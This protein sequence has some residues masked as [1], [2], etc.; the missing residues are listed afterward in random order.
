[1]APG[2]GLAQRGDRW[3]SMYFF[4]CM[5]LDKNEQ[6]SLKIYFAWILALKIHFFQ[7]FIFRCSLTLRSCQPLDFW[8]QD[9]TA[10]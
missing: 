3:I 9:E 10:P 6:L 1:M 5:T 8:T 7:M 2:I 4:F